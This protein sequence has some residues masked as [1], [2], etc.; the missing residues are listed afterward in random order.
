MFKIKTKVMKKHIIIL[1]G[2]IAL[3]ILHSYLMGE[4]GA[5]TLQFVSFVIAHAVWHSLMRKVFR[6][7]GLK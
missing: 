3:A 2:H 1:L 6:I 7:Y 5:D 4:K